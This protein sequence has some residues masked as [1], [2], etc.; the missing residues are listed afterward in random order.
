MEFA[1]APSNI[2][3]VPLIADMSSNFLSRV[4]DVSKYGAIVAGAQKN[5]GIAGKKKKRDRR[6][7]TLF[8]FIH[9]SL[10]LTVVIIREDLLRDRISPLCPTIWNYK[11]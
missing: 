4:I 9:S 3:N 10:G 2:G 5:S 8:S 1:D 7:T 6:T 11:V